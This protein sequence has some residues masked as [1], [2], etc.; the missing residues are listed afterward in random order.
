MFV[1]GV[2][3]I[4][5]CNGG[6]KYKYPFMDPNLDIDERVNDLISRMTLEEKVG[7]MMHAA[8]EIKHLNIPEYNWWG[9]CLHGVA[10]AGLAT[11]MR[12]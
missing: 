5:S 9:E 8:P 11:G 10:R 6:K 3:I 2:L 1:L 7:Q 12:I 4:E